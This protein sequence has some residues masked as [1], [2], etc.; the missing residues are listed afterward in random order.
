MN[1]FR[2]PAAAGGPLAFGSDSP[3]TGLDP[4]RRRAGGV[5]TTPTGRGSTSADAFRAHTRGGWTAARDDEGRAAP[6]RR[7]DLPP[8][9]GHPAGL[10][11]T[12]T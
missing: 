3:V 5:P 4:W 6:G 12:G 7:R 10:D 9:V 11:A 1:P 8:A 2:R